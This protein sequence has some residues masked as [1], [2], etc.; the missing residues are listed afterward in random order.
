[1]EIVPI[2]PKYAFIWFKSSKSFL[3]S[4]P[5]DGKLVCHPSKTRK[6]LNIIKI[7]FKSTYMKYMCVGFEGRKTRPTP[8]LGGVGHPGA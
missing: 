5:G 3:S 4:L 7:F 8:L 2:L 1:M 6:Y